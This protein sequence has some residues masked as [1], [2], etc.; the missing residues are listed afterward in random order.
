ML[1]GFAGS[2]IGL[3]AEKIAEVWFQYVVFWYWLRKLI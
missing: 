1:K 3:K 2:F